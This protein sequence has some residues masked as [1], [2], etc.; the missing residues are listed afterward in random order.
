M[1]RGCHVPHQYCLYCTQVYPH[2]KCSDKQ[3]LI[4]RTSEPTPGLSCNMKNKKGKGARWS[5]RFYPLDSMRKKRKKS[6]L[7]SEKKL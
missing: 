4:A 7:W 3:Y 5:I 6:M 1:S 2:H